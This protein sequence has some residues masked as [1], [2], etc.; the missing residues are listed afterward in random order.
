MTR[1]IRACDDCHVPT[2]QA[3]CP[4]VCLE[5][6][7]A[8]VGVQVEPHTV[9]GEVRQLLVWD[10][11]IDDGRIRVDVVEGT[12]VL[13][14]A[15]RTLRERIWCEEITKRIRGVTAV[16]NELE[17]R[18]T[19]GDYRPDET[20][21]RVLRTTLE[22]L[23]CL[24]ERPHLTV[25]NGWV[26]LR[27]SVRWRYQK[28]LI[29][30]AVTSIAGVRGITNFITVDSPDRIDR[31]AKAVLDAT[32]RRRFPRCAIRIRIEESKVILLGTVH[33][34][35]ERDEAVELAWCAAGVIAVEDRLV[36]HP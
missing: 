15:V 28:R 17:V 19:I 27:G 25:Q 8:F 22:A 12:A 13:T 1:V 2:R 14:G 7:I 33:T 16:S 36:V 20:L 21:E 26:T 31:A 29:E 3:T 9:A 11:R 35:A 23:T 4:D 30:E 24:P 34:C 18:L 6:K 32:L 5:T 10:P